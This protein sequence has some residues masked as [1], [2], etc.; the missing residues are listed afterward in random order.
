MISHKIYFQTTFNLKNDIGNGTFHASCI[1]NL[2]D[3]LNIK[4]KFLDF[5]LKEKKKKVTFFFFNPLNVVVFPRFQVS[6]E[7]CNM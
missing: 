7:S 4:L 1:G 5:S 3:F 2:P 6:S